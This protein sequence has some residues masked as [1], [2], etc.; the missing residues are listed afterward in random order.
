S[1]ITR[2]RNGNW[3]RHSCGIKAG[4]PGLRYHHGPLGVPAA[5]LLQSLQHGLL[6][7]VRYLHDGQYQM[8]LLLTPGDVACRIVACL[9]KATRIEKP[10]Q[11][12][13]RGH[14]VERCAAG[15]GFEAQANRAARGATEC[16]NDR[17]LAGAGLTQQPYDWCGSLGALAGIL[18]PGSGRSEQRLADCDPKLAG[19]VDD[20]AQAARRI[21]YSCHGISPSWLASSH[22]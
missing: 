9:T 8:R 3:M 15:A 10:K 13:L 19:K 11:W 4:Q 14:V 22:S 16:G 20:S 21:Q 7:R 18:C 5:R 12:R 1:G 6:N 17:G 2:V